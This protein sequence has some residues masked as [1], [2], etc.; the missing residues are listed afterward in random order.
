MTRVL[1]AR[2]AGAD[3]G[4]VLGLTTLE[5]RQEC[6]PSG[7]AEEESPARIGILGVLDADQILV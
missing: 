5:V 6:G 7:P 3:S 4:M 2:H 1:A